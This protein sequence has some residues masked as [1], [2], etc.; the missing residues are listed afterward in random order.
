[1]NNRDLKTV[2]LGMK[3]KKLM[4]NKPATMQNDKVRV[5]TNQRVHG[6]NRIKITQA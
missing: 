3:E 4:E 1:M 5:S 6:G 2:L